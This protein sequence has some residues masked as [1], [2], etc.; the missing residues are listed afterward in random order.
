MEPQFSPTFY[1]SILPPR[2]GTCYFCD[3]PTTGSPFSEVCSA[4]LA[5]G[6]EEA[7]RRASIA[8]WL[9]KAREAADLAN[10]YFDIAADLQ[11][12]GRRG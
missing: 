6:K 5:E 10:A 2:S 11:A 4:C 12:E 9:R 7:D 1:S 3:N 8:Y